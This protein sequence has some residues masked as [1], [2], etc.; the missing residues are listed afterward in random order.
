MTIQEYG[1]PTYQQY[2]RACDQWQ[3]WKRQAATLPPAEVRRHASVSTDNGC[4][5]M[6]CFCCACAAVVKECGL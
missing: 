6:D 4:G 3:E 2:S 5:C 1:K